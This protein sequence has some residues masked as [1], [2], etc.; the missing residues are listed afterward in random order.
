[1]KGW[2]TH[3]FTLY[4]LQLEAQGIVDVL[5]NVLEESNA[6]GWRELQSMT[7]GSQLVLDNAERYGFYV[8]N[9]IDEN[10]SD[11]LFSRNNIGKQYHVII[12]V[13]DF[14]W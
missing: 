4:S 5:N 1:M 6:E 7:V 9:V 12:L 13:L 8:A 3:V 14:T 10:E 2:D 11:I